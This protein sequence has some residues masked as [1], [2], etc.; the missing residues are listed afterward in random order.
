MLAHCC[1]V[2]SYFG[3]AA[4]NISG[5]T[6]HSLLH[7]PIRGRNSCELK[8][9]VLSKLQLRLANVRYIVI[10]EFSVI[11]QKMFGWIDRR[12]RQASGLTDVLFGGYS[13][14]L[15]GDL[16]KLPPVSDKPL[17]HSLPENTT[18]LMGHLAYR[19]IETV[20]KLTQNQRVTNHDQ[21]GFRQ[22]LIRLRDGDSTIADW[23]LLCSRN[24]GSFAVGNLTE[25]AVRLA[26]TNEVVA[27]YNCEMLKFLNEPIYSIKACHNCAK[28][29]RLSQDEF[30]GLEPI[31]QLAVGSRVMLTRNLW[32]EMG[33]CNGAMGEV[34]HIVYKDNDVPP[35]LP[36]AVLVKFNNYCGPTFIDNGLVPVIPVQ[37]MSSTGETYEHQQIPL[38]LSWAITI[39]GLTLSKAIVDLGPSEKVAGLA[40]VALSRVTSLYNLMVEPTSF[41]RLTAVKSQVILN[42]A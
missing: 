11:G 3:I 2:A 16:A 31:I 18:A 15:V 1:I 26:Y 24:V 27:E 19:K 25:T 30:G 7:L 21:D 8:G 28:A 20:V 39:Q 22:F 35:A 36:I 5:V 10:D 38:K 14:I 4:Y 9:R 32:I 17:Y 6:L 13:L 40:Y 33:L 37:S 41:E 29:S 42:L 34:K 23:K 12:L